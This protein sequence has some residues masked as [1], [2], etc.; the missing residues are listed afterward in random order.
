MAVAVVSVS[1]NAWL[2]IA[3]ARRPARES[4]RARLADPVFVAVRP[5]KAV[6]FSRYLR[7]E[8]VNGLSTL[9]AGPPSYGRLRGRTSR[10]PEAALT[11]TGACQH[12]RVRMLIQ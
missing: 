1:S 12:R 2:L 7:S 5:D 8:L 4:P 6:R 10:A 3:E 9:L 11:R